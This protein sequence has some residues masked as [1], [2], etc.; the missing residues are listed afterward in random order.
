MKFKTDKYDGRTL[1]FTDH[2]GDKLTVYSPFADHS[3]V[4]VEAGKPVSFTR[5]KAV[6]FAKAILKEL[7]D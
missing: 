1:K 5:E 2:F 3:H 6:K 7:G 4:Y